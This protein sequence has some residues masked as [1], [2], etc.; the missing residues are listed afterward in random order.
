MFHVKEIGEANYNFCFKGN[1]KP[2]IDNEV[3]KKVIVLEKSGVDGQFTIP[4]EEFL[5][6]RYN[7]NDFEKVFSILDVWFDS[8]PVMFTFK[9]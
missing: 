1:K 9:K 7:A 2:L 5:P 3:N 6:K 8:D 4:I